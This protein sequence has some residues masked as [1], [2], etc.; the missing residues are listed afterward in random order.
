M[1][2]RFKPCLAWCAASAAAT[3]APSPQW[4][5]DSG[6]E[7]FE[8]DLYFAIEDDEYVLQSCGF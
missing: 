6:V 5:E 3:A 1:L 4:P 2:A 8:G 7:I